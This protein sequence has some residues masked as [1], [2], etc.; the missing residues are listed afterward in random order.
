MGSTLYSRSTSRRMPEPMKPWLRWLLVLGLLA[1]L[2]AGGR[3]YP[4]SHRADGPK[5][6]TATVERGRLVARV[7][8]T[9][10]LSALVTVQV[11]SQVSGRIAQLL[12]DFNSPVKKGQV[13]A[14]IEPQLF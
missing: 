14:R 10:T 6:A 11:G 4:R 13:I 8:A 5:F 2:R 9:G 12:A 3:A 1:A 7:T